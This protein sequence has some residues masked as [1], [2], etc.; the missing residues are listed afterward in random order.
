LLRPDELAWLDDY[1]ATVRKRLSPHVGGKAKIWLEQRT[2]ALSS[3][4]L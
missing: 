4:A 1:H 3:L 2:V